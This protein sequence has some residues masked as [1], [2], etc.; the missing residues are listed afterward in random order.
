MA[1]TESDRTALLVMDVQRWVVER[2]GDDTGW[3]DTLAAT[4][5]AAR[6]AG[7]IA[8]FV[9]VAFRPGTRRLATAAPDSRR[10][11]APARSW[12]VIPVPRSTRPSR[13]SH[14]TS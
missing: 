5:D 6:A 12:R 9:T 14:K 11:E 10:C 2:F 8:I 3:L 7:V 13:R 1:A 4:A